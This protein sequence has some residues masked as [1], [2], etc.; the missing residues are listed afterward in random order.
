MGEDSLIY[1][2]V[3]TRTPSAGLSIYND[4]VPFFCHG[5]FLECK[6]W[7][8][9]RHSPTN[10]WLFIVMIIIIQPLFRNPSNQDHPLHSSLKGRCFRR[11][12]Q[13]RSED[14][15]CGQFGLVIS[16]WAMN[17]KP[18]D[19]YCCSYGF[20]YCPGSVIKRD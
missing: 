10:L 12:F 11:C 1:S 9:L 19:V 14:G 3:Y 2:S 16:V 6:L 20:C 15:I 8:F 5:P 7:V 4:Q 17:W 13:E 18:P